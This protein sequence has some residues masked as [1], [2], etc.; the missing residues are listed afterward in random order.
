LGIYKRERVGSIERE[1]EK[2]GF[3]ERELLRIDRKS[4]VIAYMLRIAY[5][6]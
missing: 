3:I 4:L 1:R 5:G 2:A 6:M